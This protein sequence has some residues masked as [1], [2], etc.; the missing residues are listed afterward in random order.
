MNLYFRE[1]GAGTPIMIL[2]GLYGSTDNWL[3]IAKTLA[4]RYR[5]ILVDLRNHG[6]SPHFQSHSFNEM[7]LDLVSLFEHLEIEK[8]HLLGHSMGGKTAMKFA[9][10]YPEKTISL[11]VADIAPVDYL[12]NP[13][14]A[15]QYAFHKKILDAFFILDM[16]SFSSR[17]EIETTLAEEI[18]DLSLRKFLLKNIYRNE[19]GQFAC[20]MNV[21]VL[22]AALPQII[23]GAN[24]NEFEDRIPILSYPVHFI[25]GTLSEY[26]TEEHWQSIKKIYPEAILTRIEGA[27]HFLHAEFPE[28][29]TLS[30]MKHLP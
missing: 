30:V 25:K 18:P 16:S 20:R 21:P 5:V 19:N 24:Y 15:L 29:F 13:A 1:L 9:A 22:R 28:A 14:S 8:A 4:E 10:D 6:R 12:E 2:H 26:I 11:N 7:V 27:S 3:P 17:S 23:S